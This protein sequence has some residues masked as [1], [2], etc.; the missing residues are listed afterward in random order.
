MATKKEKMETVEGHGAGRRPMEATVEAMNK[1]KKLAARKNG[2]SNIEAAGELGMTTLRTSSL[3]A[4]MV[5]Q[6]LI[7]AQKGENGRVTYTKVA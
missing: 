5:K 7:A 2:I 1:L 4:R 3:A 6:N